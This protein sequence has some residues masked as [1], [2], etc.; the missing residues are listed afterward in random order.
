MSS[1]TTISNYRYD[2][3][4]HSLF[5][6]IK[7]DLEIMR[8]IIHTAG[9][10]IKSM[11]FSIIEELPG[12]Y[13]LVVRNNDKYSVIMKDLIEQIEDQLAQRVSYEINKDKN[14]SKSSM[15]MIIDSFTEYMRKRWTEM[16]E[17]R[18]AHGYDRIGG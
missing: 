14:I 2:K 13:D 10:F 17:F 1:I 12:F 3:E 15:K 7:L 5:P 8:F 6:V 9:L 18:F 4:Y 16:I 11:D